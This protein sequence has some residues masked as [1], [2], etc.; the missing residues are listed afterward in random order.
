MVGSLASLA[1]FS[2]AR[3]HQQSGPGGRQSGGPGS[4]GSLLV[5]VIIVLE[6]VGANVTE[7]GLDSLLE[8]SL[9]GFL[10]WCFV[11]RVGG[12]CLGKGRGGVV[13][14]IVGGVG[15]GVGIGRH[16]VGLL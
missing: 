10:W 3:F 14:G 11:V 9:G 7:D 15:V 1:L 4:S 2:N 12:G 16:G 8:G 13:D 6:G 5:L